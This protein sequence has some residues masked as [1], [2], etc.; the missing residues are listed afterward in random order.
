MNLDPTLDVDSAAADLQYILERREPS[1]GG[2]VAIQAADQVDDL[3]AFE[4]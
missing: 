3:A 2:V 4:C 1:G